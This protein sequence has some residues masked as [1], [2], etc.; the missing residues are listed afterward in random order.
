MKKLTGIIASIG[1]AASSYA[2]TSHELTSSLSVVD[3]QGFGSSTEEWDFGY[4]YYMTP[5]VTGSAP[6]G[7]LPFVNRLASFDLAFHTNSIKVYGGGYSY[8]DANSDHTFGIAYATVDGSDEDV[9]AGSYGYFIDQN[10]RVALDIIHVDANF[11]DFTTYSISYRDLKEVS[12]GSNWLATEASISYAEEGS[13]DQLSLSVGASYYYNKNT[14]F[15]VNLSY[16]DSD[17]ED[18]FGL[19]LSGH[20]YFS[21]TVGAGIEIMREFF[22]GADVT[23]YSVLGKV[24]F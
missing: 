23:T 10:T 17:F 19:G 5:V 6:L 3:I 1:I 15:G 2:D 8:A 14:D 4:T 16:T 20:H 24:R 13:F 21:D 9:F 22:D 11:D 7:E 12:Q 18:A